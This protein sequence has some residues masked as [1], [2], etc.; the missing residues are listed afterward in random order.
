MFGRKV[1]PDQP[2]IGLDVHAQGVFPV[3]ISQPGNW[4]K[5]RR[6]PLKATVDQQTGEVHLYIDPQRVRELRR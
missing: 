6:V 4:Q 1:P 5:R 2:L 3:E